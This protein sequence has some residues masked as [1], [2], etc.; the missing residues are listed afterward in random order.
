[1]FTY[2]RR[3]KRIEESQPEPQETEESEPESIEESRK[4]ELHS[5][6]MEL[7]DKLA[8]KAEVDEK[9]GKFAEIFEHAP[10]LKDLLM[11]YVMAIQVL[12]QG[13]ADSFTY[14]ANVKD[15]NYNQQYKFLKNGSEIL[16]EELTKIIKPEGWKEG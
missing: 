3:Q 12:I 9:L 8:K 13:R 10:A 5:K 6:K 15:D 11:D 16:P 7:L 2:L 1:L 14:T 4:A